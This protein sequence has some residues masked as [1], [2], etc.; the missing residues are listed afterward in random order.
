MVVFALY[1][2]APP[3]LV[4]NLGLVD[5]VTLRSHVYRVLQ[6]P[7]LADL[8]ASMPSPHFG[9][10]LLVGIAVVRH[11]RT[12]LGRLVG[13]IL[14]AAM[15]SAIVLTANRFIVDGVAGGC[16]GLAG[17]GVA[18]AFARRRAAHRSADGAPGRPAAKPAA[19]EPAAGR[20]PRS[21]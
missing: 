7:A 20:L 2:A 21:A 15:F 17:L 6:P 4:P 3:R 10:N 14:P 16:V 8:Y 5:T 1:P 9:W 19:T 11:A 18:V 13:V 12:L